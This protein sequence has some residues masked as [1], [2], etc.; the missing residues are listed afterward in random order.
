M[1]R[2][3]DSYGYKAGLLCGCLRSGLT[4]SGARRLLKAAQAALSDSQT[5]S[6]RAPLE[7]ARTRMRA[8]RARR[9]G[10]PVQATVTGGSAYPSYVP[11]MTAAPERNFLERA[12][13]FVSDAAE[14]AYDYGSNVLQNLYDLGR[15]TVYRA[16]LGGDESY[17]RH[18]ANDTARRFAWAARRGGLVYDRDDVAGEYLH[19]LY[20]SDNDRGDAY[21][22]A[23]SAQQGL[24]STSAFGRALGATQPLPA[25]LEYSSGRVRT[26]GWLPYFSTVGNLNPGAVPGVATALDVGSY[27]TPAGPGLFARDIAQAGEEALGGNYGDAAFLAGMFPAL[28]TTK[29]LLSRIPRIGRQASRAVVPALIGAQGVSEALDTR[30]RNDTLS[31]IQNAR[32]VQSEALRRSGAHTVQDTRQVQ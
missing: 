25:E 4:P 20:G 19:R 31:V 6:S 2:I 16:G 23:A 12:S 21:E 1:W 30:R 3:D 13:D 26:Q 32:A 15:R 8:E 24:V 10:R 5:A 29:A 17:A 18:A 9:L 22:H 14:G 28:R 11:S 7:S 27:L